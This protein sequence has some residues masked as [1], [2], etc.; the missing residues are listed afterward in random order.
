[1][2]HL[3]GFLVGLVV[4][5]VLLFGAGWGQQRVAPGPQPPVNNALGDTRL[6]LAFA[7]LAGAG[8]VLG[9]VVAGRVSPL[10]T[11]VPA[12]ALLGWTGYF[13]LDRAGAIRL[14]PVSEATPG[15]LALLGG[16]IYTLLG[17]ALLIPVFMP[18]RWRR[19]EPDLQLHEPVEETYY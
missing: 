9:L 15:M 11:L 2:R 4:A 5:A 12:L 6:L 10:A 17:A 18:S 16:G 14:V 7:A 19:R 8:L 3:V 1:M 13:L